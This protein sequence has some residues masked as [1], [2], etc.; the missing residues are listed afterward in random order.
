MK[1]YRI[2]LPS[3]VNTPQTNPSL[4]LDPIHFGGS[5]RGY[6]V[7]F[8]ILGVGGSDEAISWDLDPWVKWGQTWKKTP[9]L[10]SEKHHQLV[11]QVGHNL[12]ILYPIIGFSVNFLVNCLAPSPR[13]AGPHMALSMLIYPSR[14]ELPQ[15][16]CSQVVVNDP[17]TTPIYPIIIFLDV[18]IIMINSVDTYFWPPNYI[19]DFRRTYIYTYI[20]IHQLYLNYIHRIIHPTLISGHMYIYIYPISTPLWFDTHKSS[21]YLGDTRW[22]P[23]VISWLKK[24]TFTKPKSALYKP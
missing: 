7:W 8:R 9:L 5:I 11:E 23:P 2:P 4:G 6:L 12:T 17:L 1:P 14:H 21:I 3:V 18:Y 22:Y 15:T 19:N 20:Y 16:N 24:S 13:F 10:N